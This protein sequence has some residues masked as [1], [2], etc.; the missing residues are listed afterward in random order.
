[1]LDNDANAATVAAVTQPSQ[2][3]TTAIL[4]DQIEYTP[5]S[6]FRGTETFQ[7]QAESSSGLRDTATVTVTVENR[8]PIATDD[9]ASTTAGLPVTIPVLSTTA[10][11]TPTRCRS[12]LHTR[13]ERHGGVNGP[14]D[15]VHPEFRVHR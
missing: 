14:R 2:G 13:R 10:T 9:A 11:W 8:V 5:P 6:G 15:R 1:M 12:P 3:G 4:A 7:Y